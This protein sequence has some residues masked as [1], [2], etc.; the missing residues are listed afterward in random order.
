MKKECERMSNLWE[1]FEGIAN[2]DEV[3]EAKS[4]YTPVEA[5]AYV[6]ILEK[7]EATESQSGLPM[8]KAQFRL[9]NNRVVF[10]NMILQNV[11]NPEWTARNIAQAVTFV[12]KVTGEDVEFTSLGDL[13]QRVKNTVLGKQYD[14]TVTY[15]KNDVEM[16]FAKVSVKGEYKELTDDDIPF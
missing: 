6:A 9:L 10:Y 4:S 16:K 12:N 7:F 3:A 8:L 15:G 13:A 5:G 2:A 1:R 11:N 14:I